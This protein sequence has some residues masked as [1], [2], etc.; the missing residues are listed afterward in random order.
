LMAA[1]WSLIYEADSTRGDV[2]GL[3]SGILRVIASFYNYRMAP[4]SDC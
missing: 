3:L 2:A 1:L 4:R